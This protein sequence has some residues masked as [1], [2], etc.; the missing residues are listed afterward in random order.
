M[1]VL[2]GWSYGTA[3]VLEEWYGIQAWLTSSSVHVCAH[4]YVSA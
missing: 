3:A 1:Y 2:S 4:Y